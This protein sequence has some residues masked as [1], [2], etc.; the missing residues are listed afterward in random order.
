MAHDGIHVLSSAKFT[1]KF[2]FPI[3]IHPKNQYNFLYKFYILRLNRAERQEN[4]TGK[5][6]LYVQ[7]GIS[8]HRTSNEGLRR[9][10]YRCD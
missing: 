7:Q 9:P 5:G 2:R 1:K 8:K 4:I 3:E 10:L 6:H